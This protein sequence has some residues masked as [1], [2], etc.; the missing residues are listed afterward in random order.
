MLIFIIPF[1]EEEKSKETLMLVMGQGTRRV[2]R[3]KGSP[4]GKEKNRRP[5]GAALLY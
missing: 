3:A 2:L 5:R 1:P 4:K